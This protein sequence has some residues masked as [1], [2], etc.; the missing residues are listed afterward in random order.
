ME[1]VAASILQRAVE[2]DKKEQYTMAL[3]LYQEG[4]QVLV[5]SIKGKSFSFLNFTKSAIFYWKPNFIIYSELKDPIRKKH[6]HTRAAE[7]MDRAERVKALIEE[8]KSSGKYREHMKIEAGAVGHG[9]GSVFGRFLDATVTQIRIEEPY[10]RTFHQVKPFS[11]NW[12]TKIIFNNLIN[13]RIIV[14]FGK[15]NYNFLVSVSKFFE[16]LRANHTEVSVVIQD[17]VDN[18]KRST[19]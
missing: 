18:Y 17:I 12:T 19:R 14:L 6:F 13:G 15:Y 7:Y 5:D 11:S 8:K 3:V 16:V 9:Y 4:L 2:K 1:S 10:I